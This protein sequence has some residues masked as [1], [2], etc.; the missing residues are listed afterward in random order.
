MLALLLILAA[1]PLE[2]AQSLEQNGEDGAALALLQIAVAGDPRWA[3]ARVELG[4]L[5]LKQGAS[6]QAF[7]Q[8][9]IA[10]SL[11][12]ENP[13]AHYL[14]ALAADEAGRRN[15]SRRA[16][17]VALVLREGYADAQVRLAGVLSAEGDDAGAARLLRPYVAAHPDANGARL[18]LAEALMRS[19]DAAGAEKELRALLMVGPLKVLAGRKLLALLDSQGRSGEAQKLR[20][21]IDPPARQL[22]EL[23]PSSR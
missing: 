19:G 10:R 12:P 2:Q 9:D 23:K 16:L 5:Q 13:R 11:A 20:Q 6:E 17:E 14:F 15:E 3:M 4:R 21:T 18:Q 7:E 8:L 1:S 22:R